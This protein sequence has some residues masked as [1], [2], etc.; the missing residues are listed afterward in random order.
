M[1]RGA[2][3]ATVHG[4]TT[5]RAWLSD[6]TTTTTT[7]RGSLP[8]PEK[9]TTMYLLR[10]Q[11]AH[12]AVHVHMWS[13]SG[14]PTSHLEHSTQHQDFCRT[15]ENPSQFM[16]LRR[17]HSS[18]CFRTNPV[19][20]VFTCT[21]QARVAG[22]QC[23]LDI[24]LDCAW[25]QICSQQREF[26]QSHKAWVSKHEFYKLYMS[27]Q[28]HGGTPTF[29]LNTGQLHSQP[30]LKPLEHKIQHHWQQTHPLWE[31]AVN[32]RWENV[33]GNTL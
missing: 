1:G 11:A 8:S 3:Q 2:W 28:T 25:E 26:L 32:L 20:D 7:F 19:P 31:D 14:A 33:W 22:G 29:V 6:W 18:T 24:S 16:A 27:P 5:S 15:R 9:R 17:N 4:V 21:F 10:A 30:L 12:L 23:R 13:E